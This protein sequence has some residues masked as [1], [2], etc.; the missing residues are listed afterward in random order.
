MKQIR[1]ECH[2]GRKSRTTHK[3]SGMETCGDG[4][5]AVVMIQDVRHVNTLVDQALAIFLKFVEWN[6]KRE[7]IHRTV[8]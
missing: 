5:F 1:E 4:Q 6:I 2:L 7:V 3:H 8:G